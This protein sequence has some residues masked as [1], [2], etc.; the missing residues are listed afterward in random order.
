[1]R[2]RAAIGG[3][4]TG[5][6]AGS[7][8]W[9][10][11]RRGAA[12]RRRQ[13]RWRRGGA[14][15]V[16]RARAPRHRHGAAGARLRVDRVSGAVG[17]RPTA[18]SRRRCRPTRRTCRDRRLVRRR[19]VG[20][21]RA[22]VHARR[23]F[24]LV[25]DTNSEDML[26][27]DAGVASRVAAR[28]RCPGTARGHRALAG[29]PLR[30]RRRAQHGRRRGRRASSARAAAFARRRRAADRAPRH[31]TRCR[32][33]LRL[34]QHLFYSANSDE[35]PITQNHWVACASCHMEGRS[36]AVT[37]LFAQGPR[38]TPSNAGGMLGTGFLF[39]TADRTRVQ[40]YWHTINVEQGGL[41]RSASTAQAPLLDALAAYVDH[42]IPLPIPPTTDPVARRRA[43]PRCSSAPTSAARAATPARA[44]PTRA[45]ATRRSISAGTVLLHDVGTCVTSGWP[46]VAHQ[47]RRRPRARRVPFDTPSLN[48]SPLGAVPPRRQ[49]RDARRRARRARSGGGGAL[50]GDR[51]ALVEYCVRCS[52][53]S[54]S[55]ANRQSLDRARLAV[56]SSMST[57]TARTCR[58][59]SATL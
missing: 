10:R 5:R 1:M 4:R 27:V 40:D 8:I 11:G 3:W 14:R 47:R 12:R 55:L 58:F 16:V 53:R 34:G 42:A 9:R 50:G 23:R 41:V 21:A 49:R 19:R 43:A 22:R 29:R 32:R 56:A 20:A 2:R 24:A 6:R 7:T 15:A 28:G 25:V 36:D 37:W 44:S 46:D 39:R 52:L 38:D 17:P 26:V 30:V 54:L 59:P 33:T 13:R 48:G 51:A 57:S 18:P 45:P 31:T 35:Y